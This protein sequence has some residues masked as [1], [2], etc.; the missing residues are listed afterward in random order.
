MVTRGIRYGLIVLAL[1]LHLPE[2]TLWVLAVFAI[3]AAF[4]RASQV[5]KEE[6]A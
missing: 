6:R 2:W 3:L 5:A 4:V 1:T